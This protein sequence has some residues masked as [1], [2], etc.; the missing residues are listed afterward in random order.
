[1]HYQDIVREEDI[2]RTDSSDRS[3]KYITCPGEIKIN[4]NGELSTIISLKPRVYFNKD[5]KFEN[6][7]VTWEGEM[8]KKRIG[9]LLPDNYIE[10]YHS[11]P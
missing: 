10:S 2:R 9:D 3:L 5:G 1:L 11:N 6:T 8:L 7:A 4:Y